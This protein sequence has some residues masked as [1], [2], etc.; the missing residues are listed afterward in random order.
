MNHD[1]IV[2]DVLGVAFETWAWTQKGQAHVLHLSGDR[3]GSL[4]VAL[5]G[6][7]VKNPELEFSTKIEGEREETFLRMHFRFE[8]REL[9]FEALLE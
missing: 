9:A 4:S 2:D 5:D 3:E 6:F 1:L 7:E 8:E